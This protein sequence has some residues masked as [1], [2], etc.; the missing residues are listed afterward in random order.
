MI[1]IIAAVKGM[2]GV[3]CTDYCNCD[4]SKCEN[5]DGPPPALIDED[6][7]YE[8]VYIQVFWCRNVEKYAFCQIFLF[9]Y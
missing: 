5:T 6:L 8:L 1:P 2:H 3:E 4:P 7:D 9:T